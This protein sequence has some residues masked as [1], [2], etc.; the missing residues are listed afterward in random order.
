MN[1]YRGHELYMWV[2]IA[3]G[4][5]GQSSEVV[6]MVV[7]EKRDIRHMSIQSLDCILGSE[8]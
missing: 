1:M 8:L 2:R 7:C 3:F 6:T 5:V 4:D